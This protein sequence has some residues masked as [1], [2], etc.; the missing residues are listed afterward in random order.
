M[1][2]N[3]ELV[4]N[5]S[6]AEYVFVFGGDGRMIKTVR[7]YWDAETSNG[8]SLKF[9]GLNYGHVGFLLNEPDI[10]VF[11][12]LLAGKIV[13]VEARLLHAF[14][15]DKGGSLVSEEY[16]LNDFYF[17][18]ATKETA[19]IRVAVNGTIYRERLVCDGMIVASPVGSTAYNAAAKGPILPIS[20]NTMVLTGIC[21][22]I[23][24]NWHNAILPEDAKVILEAVETKES[25][26]RFLAEGAEVPDVVRVEI[27][28][29]LE[30]VTLV[31]AKSQDF[32]K[33][34]LR[35]QLREAI[36]E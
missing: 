29:S 12:E 18:R 10:G 34:N 21:P 4:K 11:E 26:I 35:L 1:A 6:Q 13:P 36:K 31:F 17:E 22:S 27:E 30:T 14:L 24:A 19:K 16:A 7:T 25:P 28:L 3:F 5:P 8:G 33:K 2:L 32:N 23:F 15:Y 20:A 9:F